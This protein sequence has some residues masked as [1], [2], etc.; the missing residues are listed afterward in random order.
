MRQF[1]VKITV[2]HDT[3]KKSYK[4]FGYINKKH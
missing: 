1:D 3:A 2:I 4:R